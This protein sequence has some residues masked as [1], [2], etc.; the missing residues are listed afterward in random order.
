[1]HNKFQKDVSAIQA[2]EAIPTILDAVA[3]ITG[4]GF[5]CVARVT[6]DSWVTCAVLDKLDF[7][8]KPGDPL[9]IKTTLCEKVRNT[10]AAIVI[11]HVSEDAVYCDHHTPAIY[12]F[13]SY[14][15]IP[16]I[17]KNGDYFG[18]LCGLDPSPANLSNTAVIASMTM[19]AE[20]ISIQLT[21]ESELVKVNQDLLDERESAE[22]REQFIAVLGHDVRNPLSAILTATQ[23]MQGMKDIPARALSLVHMINGSAQRI[24]GLIDDVVD[25]TRGKMGGGIGVELCQDTSISNMLEHVVSELASKYSQRHIIV[26]IAPNI[27]L[28]CD[29]GRIGQL[30][31]NLLKNAL[32]HGNSIEPVYVKAQVD[33]GFF[34]LSVINAGTAIPQETLKQL[35]KPFW[36][37]ASS[38]SKEG[39]GLGLFIVSEI[40]HSHGGDVRVVSNE[41]FTSFTFTMKT[42]D[43]IERR[44]AKQILVGFSER[45][46]SS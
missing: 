31:S 23:I 1:M 22:L 28:L 32:V 12:G 15:S 38:T 42:A 36:R 3:A 46:H 10:K 27:S 6:E 5:V 44:Q 30:L 39:L 41:E 26:D 21:N 7:G 34:I 4:L 29:A 11:N 19:F 13:Q 43:F 20:L 9:D 35:F 8:L 17:R 18:T 40:A 2:I 14:I 24:S 16:I 45:R 37:G 33:Q 25:F